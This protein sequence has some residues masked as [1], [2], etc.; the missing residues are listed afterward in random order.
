MAEPL[1]NYF[2]RKMIEELGSNLSRADKKFPREEFLRRSLHGLDALELTPRGRHVAKILAELLPKDFEKASKII[3]A[4]LVPRGVGG[5][6]NAMDPF[7]YMPYTFYVAEHGLSHFEA[8]MTLQY[9][10]TKL[11]TAEFSIR[12]FIE[13]DEGRTLARLKKWTKDPDEHIRRLVSE[14]TRPRLPWAG[15]LKRF[16]KDPTPVLELLELLKDDESLYVRRSVANNLNDIGKDHPQLLAEIAKRWL[17][18]ASTERRWLVEH[19][20]RDAIKKGDRGALEVLGHSAKPKVKIAEAIATP[21]K[22]EIGGKTR[23]A[24]LVQSTAKQAQS[25]LVDLGMHFVKASG[26]TS[27]KV[28][29]LKRIELPPRG[30]VRLEKV[31]S[32]AEHTTRT[33]HPGLH[34]FDVRVNGVI[35]EGGALKVLAR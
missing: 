35:F 19:A 33:P 16:Q 9:E 25:L 1:K 21:A 14:G 5:S 22:V 17:K 8:S 18:G 6:G 27:P 23:V 31:I 7:K 11:F 20:L 26:K 2:N 4:S 29:K 24:I 30:E 28:F 3:L 32:F 34:R 12:S 13:H 10:L 15:R